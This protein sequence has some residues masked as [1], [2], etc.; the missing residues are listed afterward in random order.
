MLTT[1][2]QAALTQTISQS[3][4][5]DAHQKVNQL[6]SEAQTCK[7]TYTRLATWQRDNL[8]YQS[9][10]MARAQA[11]HNHAKAPAAVANPGPMPT[12]VP[13]ADT[14]APSTAFGIPAAA[15]PAAGSTPTPAASATPTKPASTPTRTTTATAT[16][17]GAPSTTAAAG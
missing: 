11:A 4:A 2:D 6:A 16:P 14:C 3:N 1:S 8:A 10:L 12:Q 13:D 17:T 7:Q 9:Y 15:L 5:N